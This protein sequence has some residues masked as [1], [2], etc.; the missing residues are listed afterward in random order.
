MDIW[1]I[2]NYFWSLATVRNVLL[3]ILTFPL[4]TLLVLLPLAKHFSKSTREWLAIFG[5]VG[6]IANSVL[7]VECAFRTINAA[8][9]YFTQKPSLYFDS[10][11]NRMVSQIDEFESFWIVYFIVFVVI[12]VITWTFTNHYYSSTLGKSSL[13]SD[14][15]INS[16]KLN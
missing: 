4:L 8:I 5:L 9:Y 1:D 11:T 13:K 7:A 16:L 14:S 6:F 3:L 10:K 15:G 2:F 12:A